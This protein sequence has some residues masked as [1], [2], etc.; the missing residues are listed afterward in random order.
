MAERVVSLQ[1]RLVRAAGCVVLAA[2]PV[3]C[4][5]IPDGGGVHVGRQVPAAG[6]LG[7]V[8]V[9]VLP[10]PPLP[11]MSPEDI[12]HGFLRA[13]VNADGGFEIARSYLT[14]RAGQTWQPGLEVTTY[15]DSALQIS[16]TT[17][18]GASRA[19]E[20]T[21]PRVGMIDQRGDFTPHAGTVRARFQLVRQAGQWRIDRLPARAL[22]STVDALRAFRVADVYYLN[23][24]GS[25]LVPEQV[26]LR[27]VS[28]G[29]TTA[30][31]RALLAGPG[32]WLAPA[33]RT[34][35]PA[36]TDLIGNVPVDLSG[37]AEVNLSADARKASRS[38]L[39]GMSAQIVWTLRQVSEI[40]SVQLLVDG[41]PLRVPGA[42]VVQPRASWSSYD[43]A[44]PP[45]TPVAFYAHALRW[46]VVGGT[47]RGFASTA[48]GWSSAALSA[49][50]RRMAGVVRGRRGAEFVAAPVGGPVQ[51]VLHADAVTAPS[52]DR[53]GV[54]FAVARNGERQWVAA[55]DENGAV[56]TVSADLA[57]FDGVVQD[58]R[59]S[60]DGSRVAAVVGSRGSGRLLIGRVTSARGSLH[61]GSFRDVLPAARDVR[62][63][64]WDGGD[65]VVVTAADA[66]GGREVLSVDV[67]GYGSRTIP[68]AGVV[69]EPVDV[70]ASPDRPLFVVAGGD[71]W[72]DNRA[73]GWRH[74]G[75]GGRPRY[76]D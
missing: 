6:G 11:R 1:R 59:L 12:V 46:R 38:Q 22:M 28:R 58:L 24:P 17:A 65:Q 75:S 32:R 51:A 29:V 48:D 8:D 45:V 68:T 31:V 62:G 42:P 44:A 20:V 27:P 15:D 33:V 74:I 61:L 10:P 36:G 71:V 67:D 53:T 4:A 49:D 56:Q 52:F 63:V 39:R 66:S 40:S 55:V 14:A 2:A 47:Q 70:A 19:V 23:R 64:S 41:S 13:M 16:L 34:A 21:A 43:P 37:V 54:A 26:L 73:G 72:E 57:L 69:G 35:F 18:A 50:G 5:G 76:A 3:A 25:A 9:R 30:L 60:R 7:D